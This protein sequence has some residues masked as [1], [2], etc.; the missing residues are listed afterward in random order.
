MTK[1]Q[2]QKA[3]DTV[4]GSMAETLESY[5]LPEPQIN[6]IKRIVWS[7]LDKQFGRFINE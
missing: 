2:F 4:I 5:N 6:T 3:G 1:A 7:E